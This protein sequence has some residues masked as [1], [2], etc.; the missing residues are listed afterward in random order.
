[1]TPVEYNDLME[2]LLNIVLQKTYDDEL[3]WVNS[4]GMDGSIKY[5]TA[6]MRQEINIT[7]VLTESN[8]QYE[9]YD[10]NMFITINNVCMPVSWFACDMVESSECRAKASELKFVLLENSK[11]FVLNKLKNLIV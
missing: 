3:E 2:K 7:C 6:L 4:I 10:A 5:E 8:R 1:M 9:T 11:K